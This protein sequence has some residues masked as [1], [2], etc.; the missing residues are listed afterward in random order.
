MYRLFYGRQ[1]VFLRS[2]LLRQ[3][4]QRWILKLSS[5]HVEN[6]AFMNERM[7]SLNRATFRVIITFYLFTMRDRSNIFI[8]IEP[9]NYSLISTLNSSSGQSVTSMNVLSL[10]RATFRVINSGGKRVATYEEY[11]WPNRRKW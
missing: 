8:F 5:D 2:S 3:F 9:V 11:H 7:L 10:N 6:G 4:L 1:F